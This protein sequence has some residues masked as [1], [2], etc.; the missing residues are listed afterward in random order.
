VAVQFAA[1]YTLKATDT[2]Y[3]VPGAVFFQVS[4]GKIRRARIYLAA[5]ERA[6]VEAEPKRRQPPVR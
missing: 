3:V 2:R 6:E 1:V 4:E 5:D